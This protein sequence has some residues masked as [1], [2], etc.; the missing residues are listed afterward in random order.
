M[1]QKIKINIFLFFLVVFLNSCF[2]DDSPVQP[3]I[4]NGTNINTLGL[5]ISYDNQLFF[6]LGNNTIVKQNKFYEWDLSF[7]GNTGSYNI[8]LNSAKLMGVITLG[9]IKFDS[10]IRR[11]D[12]P[13]HPQ[14]LKIDLKYDDANGSPNAFQTW[15]KIENATVKSLNLVYAVFLGYNEVGKDLGFKKMQIVSYENNSYIIKHANFDNSA[16]KFDTIRKKE[17]LSRL[18]F[19]FANGSDIDIFPADLDYD[20][21]FT[22]YTKVFDTLGI[23]DFEYSVTGALLNSPHVSAAKLY[24]ANFDSLSID[25]VIGLNFSTMEDIIGYDWKLRNETDD[26]YSIVP[27][28]VYIIKDTDGIFYKL[29][30]INFYNDQGEKGY[31]QIE[32]KKL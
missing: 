26:S 21:L 30:F 32:Y 31:P 18:P 19:S 13:I 2:E 15:W 12:L 4:P 7:E 17:A 16:L 11:I 28:V 20:L 29:R 25:N 14:K 27:S 10:V 9:N 22:K 5:G 3:Y 8:R 6:D 23:K 24:N 1:S